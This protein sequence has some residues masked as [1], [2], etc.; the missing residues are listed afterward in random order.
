MSSCW[1]STSILKVRCSMS[2]GFLSQVNNMHGS[3]CLLSTTVPSYSTCLFSNRANGEFVWL[4]S[5]IFKSSRTGGASVICCFS[6][7]RWDVSF[8]VRSSLLFR[9]KISVLLMW[10]DLWTSMPV[11]RSWRLLSIGRRGILISSMLAMLSLPFKSFKT[12]LL[13]A[14]EFD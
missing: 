4:M 10:P 11:L 9:I 14:G 13:E 1:C 5:V 8:L 3:Y 7:S 6:M 2:S 12:R